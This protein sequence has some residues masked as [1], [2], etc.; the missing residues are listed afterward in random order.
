[1]CLCNLRF[2]VVALGTY[3]VEKFTSGTEIEAEVKVV[4]GLDG[5]DE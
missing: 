1:M 5:S 2:V 4:G 3:P